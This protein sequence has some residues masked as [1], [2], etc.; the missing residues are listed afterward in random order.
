[1]SPTTRT[2]LSLLSLLLLTN[3]ASAQNLLSNPDAE[4]ALA[5]GEIPDW[6]EVVATTWTY[7][8]ANPAP[9]SGSNYFFPGANATAELRQDVDVSASAASIDAGTQSY[10]FF[11]YVRSFDQPPADDARI[12][13]EYLDATTALLG[14][15]DS[16]DIANTAEWQLV[17]TQVVVPAGTRTLR[18]RLIGTRNAGTNNDAY[19]DNLLLRETPVENPVAP[20]TCSSA[21]TGSLLVPNFSDLGGSCA[22]SQCYSCGS[23]TSSLEGTGEEDVYAFS[24]QVTGDVTVT[25]TNLDCGLDLYVLDDSSDPFNGCIEGDTRPGTDAST[26]TFG[27]TAGAT[28]HIVVEVDEDESSCSSGDGYDLSFEVGAATG[29]LEDCDNGLD[30][31]LSGDADCSDSAC[32]TDPICIGFSTDLRVFLEGAYSGQDTMDVGALYASNIPT[33]QPYSDPAFD[34]TPLD[35]DGLDSLDTAAPDTMIDWVLVSLRSDTAGPEVGTPRAGILTRTGLILNP[36]GSSLS[37]PSV[38]KGSYFA[39]VRHRNHMPV[40]SASKVDFS[41]G[42]ASWDFRSSLS[43]AYSDTGDP[44]KDLGGSRFGMFAC[45]LNLDG[46]STALDFNVWLPSTKAVETGYQLEDCTFDG[47]VTATDFNLWL[48][49]TKSAVRS[50]VPE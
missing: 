9:Q 15:F 35:Y 4:V 16:G 19:F 37:F 40:M 46:L 25:L 41:S 5:G 42:S 27:C 49:N 44:M 45:D 29:C 12:V 50:Q 10:D 1:M 2:I 11:G 7:R 43:S 17:S 20:L 32:W 39:V 8:S 47:N 22:G 33:H 28:Y 23:P 34:G 38:L 3:S 30:D 18:V 13:I 24:C 36:D 31:D 21:V 6:T 48:P 26:V 14:S